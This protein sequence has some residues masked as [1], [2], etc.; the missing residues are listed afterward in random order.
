[1]H[2]IVLLAISN[3]KKQISK[4]VCLVK[5]NLFQNY[6]TVGFSKSSLA[7]GPKNKSKAKS[8]CTVTLMLSIHARIMRLDKFSFV[9]VNLSSLQ[10]PSET[11]HRPIKIFFIPSAA[12]KSDWPYL[13]QEMFEF[14]RLN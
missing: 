10:L 8:I 2:G 9:V 1:M 12:S 11:S 3:L 14:F 5:I 4:K 13:K 7:I 6:G